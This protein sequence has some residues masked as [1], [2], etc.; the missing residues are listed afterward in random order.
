MLIRGCEYCWCSSYFQTCKCI[1]LYVI[2]YCNPP[3]HHH[4]QIVLTAWTSLSFFHYPSLSSIAPGRSS[5]LH[6]VSIQSWC[7]ALLIGQ[8]W[9]IRVP[10]IIREH[11][12]W[13]FYCFSSST[14]HVLFALFEWFVRREAHVQTAAVLGGTAFRICSR[15]HAVS[16]CSFHLAFSRIQPQRPARNEGW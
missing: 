8:H 15:Q 2:I 6:L 9:H 5:R 7:K 10:E 3:P 1:D 12:L 4:H 11:H 16:L 13:V 14:P